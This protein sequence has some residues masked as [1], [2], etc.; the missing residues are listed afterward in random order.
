MNAGGRAFGAEEITEEQAWRQKSS[1]RA[2]NDQ[3]VFGVS[4]KQRI[5]KG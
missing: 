4:G 3:L 5:R 2:P 1:M